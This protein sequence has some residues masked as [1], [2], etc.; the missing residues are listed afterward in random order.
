MIR[1]SLERLVFIFVDF[2]HFFLI[3]GLWLQNGIFIHYFSGNCKFSEHIGRKGF[4][5]G[6]TVL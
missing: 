3:F 4:D 5:V 2:D 1:L 6:I